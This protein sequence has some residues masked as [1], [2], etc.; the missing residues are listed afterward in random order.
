MHQTRKGQQ[1]YFG[2]NL[3]IGVDNRTKLIHWVATTPASV[4]DSKMRGELLHGNETCV[5]GDQACRGFD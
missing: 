1:W 4:H 3:H 2:I 5:Y